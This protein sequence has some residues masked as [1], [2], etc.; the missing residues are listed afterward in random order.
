VWDDEAVLGADVS[1]P[2][3]SGSVMV[4]VPPNSQNGRK[5]RLKGKG[6]PKASGEA[7]GDLYWELQVMTPAD[8]SAD[9]REHYEALRQ[10][11]SSRNG[12]DRIRKHL[13][14]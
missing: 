9:E 8:A 1:V 12:R 11:R 4:R 6:L 2:T 7:A 13:V 10:L 14:S 5:L 3:P